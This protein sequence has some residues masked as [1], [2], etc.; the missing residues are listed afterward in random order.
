MNI[1][2]KFLEPYLIYILFGSISLLI[3]Y[4]RTFIQESAKI[5][6]LKKRNKELIEETE[7]IKKEHQLDISKRKYQYESKKEQYLNFFKLIDSFTSEANISMQEKLIPILNRFSEDYLDASTNNNKNG[8][9]KAITEM[10]NQMRKISFDSIAELTKLRQ[11]TN[12]IRVIASKEILQKLDLLELSYEKVTAKS[13]TMMSA[14]PQLLL[15]D[16]QDEINKHQK[17]I[18]LSG[19]DSKLINDEI[20]ELMRMELNEI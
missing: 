12:T 2:L 6:A 15:A 18:E 7:S 20:I 1:D 13:N 10:S 9:N 16:N 11:E 4:V 3:L 14:L 5:S 8:E 17:D 19:R